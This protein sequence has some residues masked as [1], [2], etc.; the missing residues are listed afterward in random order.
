VLCR[1]T[2]AAVL[3]TNESDDARDRVVA[4]GWTGLRR[5]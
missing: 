3:E 1:F 5:K 4:E 2:D